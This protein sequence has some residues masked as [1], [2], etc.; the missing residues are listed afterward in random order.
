MELE[1]TSFAS[2]EELCQKDDTKGLNGESSIGDGH[3]GHDGSSH[4]DTSGCHGEDCH[5]VDGVG[6]H[7]EKTSNQYEEDELLKSDTDSTFF[8]DHSVITEEVEPPDGGFGWVV[9]ACA[10]F[11]QLICDGLLFSFGVLYISL[12]EHFEEGKSVTSW[13]GAV[14]MGCSMLMGPLAGAL[15]NKIGCRI[16]GMLGSVICC[17][18]LVISTFSPN[19]AVLSITY[20]AMAGTGLSFVYLVSV[21]MVGSYFKKRRALAN[22]IAMC[23][24]GIGTFI[25][26]P[27]LRFLLDKYGWNGTILILAG[28]A[29]N[30]CVFSAF[31][32]PVTYKVMKND[33]RNGSIEHLGDN[34]VIAATDSTENCDE[35]GRVEKDQLVGLVDGVE[36][37]KLAED[38]PKTDSGYAS[39]NHVG[40]TKPT[41]LEVP[42]RLSKDRRISSL[43][44][45]DRFQKVQNNRLVALKTVHQL[46]HP[47]LHRMGASSNK[48]L[49][50]QSRTSRNL[51]TTQSLVDTYWGKENVSTMSRRE[52]FMSGSV[53]TIP[54]VPA[55][56]VGSDRQRYNSRLGQ[57]S[58][59]PVLAG[60]K[61][62]SWFFSCVEALGIPLLRDPVLILIVL[63]CVFWTGQSTIYTYLVDY[64]LYR[65][66][67]KHSASFLLSIIGILNTIGR[68][69]IGWVTDHPRV[70][71]T[72][73]YASAILVTGVIAFVIPF[74][75]SFVA[76]AFCSGV[77]GICMATYVSLRSIIVVDLMGID[78]LTGSFGLVISFQ[79]ISYIVVPPIAGAI[80]EMTG[81]YIGPFMSTGAFYTLAAIVI[82][83]VRILQRRC[84]N[85]AKDIDLDDADV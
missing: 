77:F 63:S 60:S 54:W 9:C 56:D 28:I 62:H 70:D 41:L 11:L 36:N 29:L 34:V 65:D 51:I 67:D 2:E 18:S 83:P 71:S 31:F 33:S 78:K 45:L 1:T 61:S 42:P 24:S 69:V 8:D 75:E 16:T 4:G 27:L 26:S 3:H 53:M 22:G 80:L 81:T 50:V 40:K 19:I 74:C 58:T 15:A 49:S 5:H 38:V 66:I 52:I 12:L 30:G 32:R 46:S 84:Q 20:G 64:A 6:H 10:F 47:H 14:F 17:V 59:K 73:V 72:L 25:M 21:V 43:T 37:D 55:K 76:L 39:N 7:G 13:V 23:G 57:L 85:K 35:L 68:I 44:D 79:G 82:L 48:S